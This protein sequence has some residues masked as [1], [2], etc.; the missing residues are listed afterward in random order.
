[1]LR[2][3]DEGRGFLWRMH[4][5]WR[6]SVVPDGVVAT[7]ESITLSRPVPIGLGLVSRPVISRVARESMTTALRAWQRSPSTPRESSR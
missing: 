1:R 5:Y 4:S 6:F 3:P 7:C 2:S